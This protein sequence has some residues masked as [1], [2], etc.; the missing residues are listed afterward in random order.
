MLS[1]ILLKALECAPSAF[2]HIIDDVRSERY[3]DRVEADR[4]DLVEMVAHIADIEDTFLDRMRLAHEQPGA[5]VQGFDP[6]E[7][8]SE[9]HY[10]SRDLHHELEVYRN[11]RNDTLDFLRNLQPG[12]EDR[13]ILHSEWGELTIAQIAQ[14]LA[15]HDLYHLEQASRYLR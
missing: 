8:A 1:P 12:E 5:A 15:F 6:T 3:H 7:R 10:A 9:K 13:T 14:S 2:F 4:F 11:R